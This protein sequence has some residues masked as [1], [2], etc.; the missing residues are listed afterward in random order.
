MTLNVG[1]GINSTRCAGGRIVYA[2]IGNEAPAGTVHSIITSAPMMPGDSGGPAF[3]L[4]NDA[5]GTPRLF[6]VGV[7]V[8]LR[9]DLNP[10][11]F[12]TTLSRPDPAWIQSLIEQ[13]RVR[14]ARAIPSTQTIP[15]PTAAANH[16]GQSHANIAPVAM[17]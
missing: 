13:D 1:L 11:E 4:K 15:L 14:R 16:L 7:H 6:L 17:P 5:T 2:P 10:G 8:E 9:V 12:R 3:I